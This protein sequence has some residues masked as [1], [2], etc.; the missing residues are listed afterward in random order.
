MSGRAS[1]SVASS[2]A[3][4]LRSSAS[5]TIDRRSQASRLTARSNRKR[6]RALAQAV[7]AADRVVGGPCPGFDGSILGGLLL[8][9]VAERN[10]IAVVQKH[11]VQIFDGGQVVAQL[12]GTYLADQRRWVGL[13][14]AVERVLG[15]AARGLQ[16]PRVV[17]VPSSFFA[18]SS[19]LSV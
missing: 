15:A 8:I 7:P 11:L 17:R 16:H 14:I 9:R 5:T 4:R 13:G 6:T 2:W 10:P 19:Q 1:R 12:R 18:M 3:K